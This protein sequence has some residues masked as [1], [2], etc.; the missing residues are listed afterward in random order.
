MRH[1][2]LAA[3]LFAIAACSAEGPAAPIIP[4]ELNH[5]ISL[6]DGLSADQGAVVSTGEVTLER[7]ADWHSLGGGYFAVIEWPGFLDELKMAFGADPDCESSRSSFAEC[8]KD[9]LDDG[10]ACAVYRQNEV[11][12]AHC[13]EEAE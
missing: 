11:Y 5:L 1:A 4:G 9:Q 8:V 13:R 12:F 3:G 7:T 6:V 10:M 2:F